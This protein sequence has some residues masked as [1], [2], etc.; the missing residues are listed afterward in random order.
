MRLPTSLRTVSILPSFA[1]WRLC[2]TIRAAKPAVSRP[3]SKFARASVSRTSASSSADSTLP[4]TI[5]MR[6][7]THW[8]SSKLGTHDWTGQGGGGFIVE[9]DAA[10]GVG[11]VNGDR[12]R[13]QHLILQ[14]A[15]ACHVQRQIVLRYHRLVLAVEPRQRDVIL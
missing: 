8:N 10:G 6:F 5:C 13:V 7:S 15:P 14:A 12:Q 3:S 11:R 1:A 4:I 9:C 2:L